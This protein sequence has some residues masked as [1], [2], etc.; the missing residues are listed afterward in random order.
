MSSSQCHRSVESLAKR[1]REYQKV[2]QISQKATRDLKSRGCK[3]SAALT[4]NSV[5]VVL[6]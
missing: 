5:F 1:L 6:R 2:R 4:R 3:K